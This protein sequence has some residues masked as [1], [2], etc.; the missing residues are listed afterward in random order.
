MFSRT[1]TMQYYPQGSV[2]CKVWNRTNMDCSYRNLVCVPPLRHKVSLELLDLSNNLI[3]KLTAHAFVVLNRLH[4]LDLSVN[5][6]THLQKDVFSGLNNLL[7]LDLSWNNISSI[8]NSTFIGLSK[9]RHLNLFLS[10]LRILSGSP[11]KHLA[12]LQT[13]CQKMLYVL[14]VQILRD[15]IAYNPW[16]LLC[17]TWLITFLL[18]FHRC[19]TYISVSVMLPV[20]QKAYLLD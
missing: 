16:K 20:S 6:I 3:P 10:N 9:L 5:L 1:S 15:S 18:I 14:L 12:S 17:M 7:R 2:T 19:S 11:F 8:D 13:P 4:N